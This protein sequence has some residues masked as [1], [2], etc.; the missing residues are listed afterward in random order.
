MKKQASLQT[1]GIIFIFTFALI[2]SLFAQSRK[3]EIKDS[4]VASNTRSLA[5]AVNY[6]PN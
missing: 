4:T 6:S 3:N 2:S 1:M 5:E